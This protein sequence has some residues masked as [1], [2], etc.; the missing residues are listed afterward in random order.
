MKIVKARFE[1]GKVQLTEPP[2]ESGPV[3]VEVVF[4][5][6]DDRRWDEIINDDTLRPDLSKEADQVLSDHRAGKTKP[7][8]PESL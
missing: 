2:P 1:N 5:D 8:N 3:D 7:L 4:L 6:E